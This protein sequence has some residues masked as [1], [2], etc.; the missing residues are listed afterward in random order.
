MDI[1]RMKQLAQALADA[2]SQQDV[3]V[4][5]TYLHPEM[6]LEN[7]AFGSHSVGLEQNEQALSR[8]FR[9]FPDYDVA[10]EGHASDGEHLVCW[11]V[12]RM[13]LTGDHFGAVPNGVRSELPI[14]I[15]F[16]FKDDLIV[17]EVF[18]F[19]LSALC[20]QSGLSTDLVRVGLFGQE[21]LM[22]G[23]GGSA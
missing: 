9:A 11:G 8:W 2:K 17:N 22:A 12:V 23:A 6:V 16:A 18:F 15:R 1:A 13:T 7:P 10:L 3:Q 21:H 4:A 14:F 5:L 20:A 19:D